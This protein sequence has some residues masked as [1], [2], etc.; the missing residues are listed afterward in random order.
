MLQH[1]STRVLPAGLEFLAELAFDLRWTYNHRADELF[2]TLDPHLWSLTHNPYLIIETVSLDHCNN[3]AKDETFINNL[4]N[5]KEEWR[6]FDSSA[7]WFAKNYPDTKIKNIAYF[8]MEFGIDESLPLYAGGLGILA[9]DYLKT[10]ED[11]GVPVIGIG[12]LYQKGYFHQIVD[13]AGMQNEVYPYNDPHSLPIAPLRDNSGEW[14]RITLTLPERTITLRVWFAKIGNTQ[15]FFLDSNDPV[16]LPIDR[17]ITGDLY[18]SGKEVRLIQE[19]ILG[20]GGFKLLKTLKIDFNLC[21]MNE[22]HAAF[23]VL[24]RIHDWMITNNC[25]NFYEALASTRAGNIFTTHTP[26]AAG[27]DLFDSSLIYHYLSHYITRC[28]ITVEDFINLGKKNPVADNNEPFNMA[29]LA[30]RGSNFVNAVSKIHQAV[31]KD[32]FS[33]LFDR[34]PLDEI[35]VDYITNGIHTPTWISE[36]SNKFWIKYCD[37]L[38]EHKKFSTENSK[39]ILKVSDA[40]IWDFEMKNRLYM[41]N[42]IQKHMNKM[43]V[44]C[45]LTQKPSFLD[46]NALYIGLARRFTEYKRLNLLLND[47]NRL[48]NILT[49][50]NYPVRILIGGKA[51]P[52]DIKGKEHIKEW[53]EFASEPELNDKI[54]FL[55]DYDMDIAQKLTG[56]I[57]VWLNCM[58]R[59]LEASGTSGM[60]ILSNGGLNCSILDGWWDEAYNENVGWAI[61]GKTEAVQYFNDD[62][63]DAEALYGLLENTVIPEF[64]NRDKNGIPAKWVQK[65]R[66]SMATLTPAFSTYRMMKEYIEKAYIPMSENYEKRNEDGGKI[67]LEI[68][69]WKNKLNKNWEG[70]HFANPS[71]EKNNSTYNVKCMIWLG[72]I[73]PEAIKV[74]LYTILNGKPLITDMKINKS[75]TGAI[76]GF[77]YEAQAAAEVPPNDYT[78]RIIPYHPD[79]AVPLEFNQILWQK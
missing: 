27:F 11:L 50:T 1:F 47:K 62:K 78:V 40:D 9:G 65:I 67:A 15:L 29:Y 75:I 33:N 2:K 13:S 53:I 54:F 8:S 44:C 58:K 74:Q 38:P 42:E 72:I 79:A 5:I 64:F 17:G 69:E 22:G 37:G 59:P 56:G 36:E 32:L 73:E 10:A 35:P 28:N 31:S 18:E 6:K 39:F 55:L 7:T 76:N 49:N 60:K 63:A 51:H 66:Q 45:N 14:L 30:I 21:H 3:L 4:N 25:G 48:R 46:P 20:I 43:Q 52:S 16:N 12:L 68:V 61:G 19:M 70:I 71:F 23:V 77:I 24:E 57:D 41:I 34:W 26:I